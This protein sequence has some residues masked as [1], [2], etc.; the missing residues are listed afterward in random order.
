MKDYEQRD[1]EAS[2]LRAQLYEKEKEN[3]FLSYKLKEI[4]KG[5]SALNISEKEF[6][7]INAMVSLTG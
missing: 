6:L 7:D 5:K 4:T 2:D 3:K 1:I